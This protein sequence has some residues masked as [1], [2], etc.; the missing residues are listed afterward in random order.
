[1]ARCATE[2]CS[3]ADRIAVGSEDG[4]ALPLWQRLLA[5]T[6]AGV[7]ADDERDDERDNNDTDAR[8]HEV[9]ISSDWKARPSRSS[10]VDHGAGVCSFTQLSPRR[11]RLC[12]RG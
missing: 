8:P 1:M 6:A 2:R 3:A 9:S 11:C 12:T 7:E 4:Q 10:A 5:L